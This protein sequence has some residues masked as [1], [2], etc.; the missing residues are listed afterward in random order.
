MLRRFRLARLVN[1]VIGEPVLASNLIRRLTFRFTGEA[2]LAANSR[3]AEP[4][5][6]RDKKQG[7]TANMHCVL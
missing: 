3:G 5:T 6:G 2:V 4:V 7:A 1:W